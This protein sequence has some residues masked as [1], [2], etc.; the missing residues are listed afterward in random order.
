VSLKEHLGFG[1]KIGRSMEKGG[2]GWWLEY[3]DV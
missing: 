2:S 1:E 3:E